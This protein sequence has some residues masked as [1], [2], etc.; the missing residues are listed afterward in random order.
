MP[1]LDSRRI[2]C[3]EPHDDTC[4]LLQHLLEQSSYEFHGANSITTALSLAQAQR[5]DL[6]LLSGLFKDGTGVELCQQIR[7]KDTRT[8][9]LIFSA[10]GRQ[11]DKQ[12]ALCAGAQDYLVKPTGIFE[13]ADTIKRLIDESEQSTFNEAKAP[14]KVERRRQPR[15]NQPFPATVFGVNAYDVEFESKTTLDNLSAGGLHLKLKQH[16]RQ[17]A[18]ISVVVRPSMAPDDKAPTLRVAANGVV[19]RSEPQTDGTYGLGIALH[20]TDFFEE[21]SWALR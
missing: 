19:L 7:S 8:P 20:K 11:S 13:L 16:L 4:Y 15:I 21:W 6:F 1:S 10:Y 2:L 5:F 18:K 12:Q 14:D 17:G 3:A 9:I